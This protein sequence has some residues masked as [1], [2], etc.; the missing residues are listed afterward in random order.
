MA[1][2]SVTNNP[3]D[4]MVQTGSQSPLSTLL[5][6]HAKR[7]LHIGGTLVTSIVIA[8]CQTP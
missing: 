7:A 1:F 4:T 8:A 3:F 6:E 5:D 2:A